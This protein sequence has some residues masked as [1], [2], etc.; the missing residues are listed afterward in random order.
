VVSCTPTYWCAS[1]GPSNCN[2]ADSAL[3]DWMLSYSVC[4]GCARYAWP[5]DMKCLV[6]S[7]Q[8]HFGGLSSL[9]DGCSRSFQRLRF[10]CALLITW[11]MVWS[12][13]LRLDIQVSSIN[14]LMSW[15]TCWLLLGEVKLDAVAWN[16][17]EN[18]SHSFSNHCLQQPSPPQQP[19]IKHSTK[20]SV[21]VRC[22]F[23]GHGTPCKKWHK[24]YSPP[25][26][27]QHPP[28]SNILLW[29]PHHWP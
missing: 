5:D 25:S 17:Y 8:M 16:R 4:F 27:N 26:S 21:K 24:T 13:V 6:Y 7:Y 2:G 22:K 10:D 18:H 19:H 9:P 12:F 1:L 14:A 20:C 28:Q 29:T 3:V 23:V 15:V 11:S